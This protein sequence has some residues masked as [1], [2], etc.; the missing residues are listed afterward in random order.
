MG[1]HSDRIQL[2]ST[3]V[4]SCL[5]TSAYS[6]GDKQYCLGLGGWASGSSKV[7]SCV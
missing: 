2:R 3:Y 6:M 7:I 1:S 4:S 5:C